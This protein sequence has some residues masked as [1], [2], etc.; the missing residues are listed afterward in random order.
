MEQLH[1]KIIIRYHWQKN[2]RSEIAPE[3]IKVLKETAMRRI[4]ELIALEGH[5]SGEL[6][7]NIR[8]TDSDPENGVEYTGWWDCEITTED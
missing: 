5:E 8:M 7:D 1:Q 4:G 2:D 6:Q 3:H